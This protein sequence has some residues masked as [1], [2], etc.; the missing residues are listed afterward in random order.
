MA[1]SAADHQHLTLISAKLL[2][3]TTS[4]AEGIWVMGGLT[5]ENIEL[6]CSISQHLIGL[7]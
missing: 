3:A 7:P 4:T 5:N 2:I 1:I 6:I